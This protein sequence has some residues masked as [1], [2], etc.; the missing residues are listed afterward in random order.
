MAAQNHTP[1]KN[2]LAWEDTAMADKAIKAVIDFL[3]LFFPVT[4][5]KRIVGIILIVSGIPYWRVVQLSGL[6][7]KTVHSLKR[8]LM[9]G[10]SVSALLQI[11]EGCGRKSKTAGL[12]RQIVEELEKGNYHTRQQVAD[13]I[14]EKFHVKVSVSAVGKM[15]KKTESTN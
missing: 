11:G 6:C 15:L 10:S 7:E 3:Q 9:N 4:L 1:T 13:M 5:S 8:E 12:E 14:D 2:R